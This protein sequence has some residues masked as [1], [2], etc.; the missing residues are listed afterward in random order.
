MR[1]VLWIEAVWLLC[2][3]HRGTQASRLV[4]CFSSH[5]SMMKVEPQD[6]FMLPA[7]SMQE[8]HV[9]IRPMSACPC[10]QL[11]YINVVDIELHQV[12]VSV[13][14][15]SLCSY[16]LVFSTQALLFI[17]LSL[18]VFVF[19]FIVHCAIFSSVGYSSAM[20]AQLI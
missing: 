16:W 13:S 2:F 6:A 7:N 19:V 5:P 8:L 12:S 10:S 20:P 1:V 11:M 3:C 18:C 15:S 14:H 4:Q 9:G 17:C